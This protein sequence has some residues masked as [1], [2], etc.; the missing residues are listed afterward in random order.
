MG[1]IIS[2]TKKNGMETSVIRI[3]HDGTLLRS[4]EL[5]KNGKQHGTWKAWIKPPD[6]DTFMIYLEQQWKH[7]TLHGYERR[8]FVHTGT[9]EYE[10]KYI[11]GR[12]VH[13][14]RWDPAGIQI[15]NCAVD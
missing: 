12:C 9:L 7:G 2:N 5:W 14:I 1:S 8:Y 11:Q 15:Y 3:D 4:E 6:A 13:E 10:K